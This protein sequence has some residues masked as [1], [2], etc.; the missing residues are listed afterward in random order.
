MGK[1]K[2]IEWKGRGRE[3]EGEEK[4]GEAKGFAEPMSHGFTRA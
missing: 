4:R 1:R 2:G 3:M